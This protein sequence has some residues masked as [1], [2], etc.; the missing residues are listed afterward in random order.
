MSARMEFSVEAGIGWAD[1][2]RIEPDRACRMLFRL[3]RIAAARV[4]GELQLPTTE[5]IVHPYTA[6]ERLRMAPLDELT[7]VYSFGALLYNMLTGRLP[8]EA[9]NPVHLSLRILESDPEPITA[10]S[11]ELPVGLADIVAR[12]LCRE[13]EGRISSLEALARALEPFA[14]TT[15]E[16]SCERLSSRP[17][18]RPPMRAAFSSSDDT[19]VLTRVS[20]TPR[21]SCMPCAS[22]APRAS[23]TPRSSVPASPMLAPRTTRAVNVTPA[24]SVPLALR[25]TEAAPP[26]DKRGAARAASWLL[27]AALVIVASL[28]G[29]AVYHA[30][31]PASAPIP[32]PER[33]WI[34][35]SGVRV[36]AVAAE[37]PRAERG[38]QPSADAGSHWTTSQR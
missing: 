37:P 33:P 10:H 6:P 24:L 32:S 12:A 30:L 23:Q 26:G 38:Q 9:E 27:G 7:E 15:Y 2:T 29:V 36:R 11:P 3:I 25:A 34:A 35:H 22:Q 21:S 20:Q 13:R 18:P 14:G 8:F 19:R 31:P 28:F 5:V 16:A 1:H 4:S 17:A